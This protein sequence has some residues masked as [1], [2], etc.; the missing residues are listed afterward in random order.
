MD[1][2]SA[3]RGQ[4]PWDQILAADQKLL[5]QRAAAWRNEKPE[6]P[7][8]EAR[9]EFGLPRGVGLPWVFYSVGLHL[10]KVGLLLKK[11]LNI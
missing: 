6:A 3:L 9:L 5:V 1:G 2:F 4:R 11:V 10:H 8:E 7:K